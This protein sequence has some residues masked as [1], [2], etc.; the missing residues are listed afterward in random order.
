MWQEEKR[1]WMK[2]GSKNITSIRK[3]AK[4]V[5]WWGGIYKGG[6]LSLKLFTNYMGSEFYV[7]IID[8]KC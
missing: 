5:N 7:N 3:H 1:S 2:E 6:K 8:E 4:R